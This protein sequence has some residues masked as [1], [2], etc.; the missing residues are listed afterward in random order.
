MKPTIW[1]DKYATMWV[2]AV[3]DFKEPLEGT[4]EYSR[5]VAAGG[6][7]TF[8]ESY[9]EWLKEADEIYKRYQGDN[10]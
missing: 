6:G 4:Q 10:E 9:A 7:S 2:C 8:Q 5:W 3:I 1:Y